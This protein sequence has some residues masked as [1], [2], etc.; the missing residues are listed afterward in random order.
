[1]SLDISVSLDGVRAPLSRARIVAVA[2]TALRGEKVKNALLSVTLVTPRAMA[3]INAEHIGHAG[4]TDVI[5]FGFARA[6]PTDPVV[7]DIYIC[8]GVARE[9]ALLHGAPVREELARLVVHGV[10][11]VLGHDHPDGEEREDSLMW[12]QQEKLLRRALAQRA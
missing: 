1:V 3:R 10:L 8:P 12:R 4:P 9:N 11:H 6:T 5:S 2:E 7:G